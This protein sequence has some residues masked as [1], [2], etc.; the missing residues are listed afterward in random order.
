V[1]LLA[2]SRRLQITA[3]L[4][5][6]GQGVVSVRE[7]SRLLGVSEMTV[8]RDLDSLEESQVVKR[9]HGGAV[10]LQ[11]E[12][13]KPFFLRVSEYD[14]QKR[15][16]G[17]TAAQ[18]VG[19]GERIILDAGT[20]TQQVAVHLACKKS[21]T[22]ITNNLA[23]AAELARCPQIETILLGGSLKHQELCTVGPMVKQGLAG[24][25]AE[26]LFLS[27]AGLTIKYGATDPDLREVEVK[28]AMIA[29]AAQVI[30][31]ADSSKWGQS[32]L[33]RIAG[34]HEIQAL[35]T[36]DA[37]PP[38]AIAALETEGVEVITPGRLEKSHLGA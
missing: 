5:K 25:A 11:A 36:D 32:K 13:E 4:G 23:A 27:A 22:V 3:L 14:P 35:V 38:E 24:L 19:E 20:T 21:L 28:Q 30:L 6:V 18:L 26:K 8:R 7:L 1:R 10:A 2:E 9:V 16:I 31:V 15:A 17:W 34:L 29:A 37:L 12:A 33:A